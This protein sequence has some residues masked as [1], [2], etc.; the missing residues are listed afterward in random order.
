MENI[1]EKIKRNLGQQI[2]DACQERNAIPK[3]VLASIG[4]LSKYEGEERGGYYKFDDDSVLIENGDSWFFA[5]DLAHH[6]VSS[7]GVD[8]DD[9][10]VIWLLG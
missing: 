4:E 6:L 9:E 10:L 7:C 2:A 5:E 3:A 8:P 1:L